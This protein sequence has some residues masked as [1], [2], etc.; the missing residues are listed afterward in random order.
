MRLSIFAL[1]TTSSGSSARRHPYNAQPGEVALVPF[2]GH[3]MQMMC[4]SLRHRC[5]QHSAS[6]LRLQ[7]DLQ[8]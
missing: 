7:Q 8:G 4:T 5:C 1:C 6:A 3:A 2:I